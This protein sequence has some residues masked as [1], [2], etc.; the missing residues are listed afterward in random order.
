MNKFC[1][2]VL[3]SMAQPSLAGS[4]ENGSNNN[5]KNLWGSDA[6]IVINLKPLTHSSFI[7]F[8]HQQR[9]EKI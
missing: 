6:K 1:V 3:L 7:L 4:L 8:F 2:I 5:A 9:T